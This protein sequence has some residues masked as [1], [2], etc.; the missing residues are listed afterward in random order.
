MLA[1]TL[2]YLVR[3]AINPLGARDDSISN[4]D[5][6]RDDNLIV[7]ESIDSGVHKST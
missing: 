5:P 1:P 3:Y 7:P 4:E 6:N 2:F